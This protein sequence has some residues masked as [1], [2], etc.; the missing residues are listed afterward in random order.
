VGPRRKREREREEKGE[1][2]GEQR[3]DEM[4]EKERGARYGGRKIERVTAGA[5]RRGNRERDD[6][7]ARGMTKRD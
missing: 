6:E 5:A 2:R 7:G 3:D 4:A 1:S